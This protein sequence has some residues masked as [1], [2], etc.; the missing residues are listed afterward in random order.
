M[1]LSAIV[2]ATVILLNVL[3]TLLC[4]SNLWFADMTSGQFREN[5]IPL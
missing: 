3:M 4:S 5:D 1:G 2:I